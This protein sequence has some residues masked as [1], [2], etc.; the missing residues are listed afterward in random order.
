[1]LFLDRIVW[2]VFVALALFSL[3]MVAVRALGGHR[4]QR[5]FS[6]LERQDYLICPDCHY[7]LRGHAEGGQCPECGHSFTP[8]S[9]RA[10]WDDMVASYGPANR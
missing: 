5:F 7:Y 8:E 3:A 10:D 6:Q 9:L 4:Q 1:M 2:P